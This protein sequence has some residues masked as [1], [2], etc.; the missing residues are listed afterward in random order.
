M[1]IQSFDYLSQNDS[2][3]NMNSAF[4]CGFQFSKSTYIRNPSPTQQETKKSSL[5]VSMP[6][7]TCVLDLLVPFKHS[8]CH[9]YE[10]DICSKNSKVEV[11]TT[12]LSR[13]LTSP[14]LLAPLHPTLTLPFQRT[15]RA[16]SSWTAEMIGIVGGL[17][18]NPKEATLFTAYITAGAII[19]DSGDGTIEVAK[20]KNV[21]WC[22]CR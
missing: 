8:N 3:Q 14:K 13:Y 15:S 20:C 10:I 19:D 11:T 2:D 5:S 7:T 9:S 6:W 17:D 21:P 12:T 1:S 4:S 18:R 16:A 22:N